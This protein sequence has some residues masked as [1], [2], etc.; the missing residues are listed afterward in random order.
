MGILSPP[1]SVGERY[2]HDQTEREANEVHFHR[3]S[4]GTRSFASRRD[5]D[6]W[7]EA[8]TAVISTP[9]NASGL[10]EKLHLHTSQ[11]YDV[12]VL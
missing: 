8:G 3:I 2:R 11:F 1:A 9:E 6:L 4:R 12:V 10:E 5:S 7:S